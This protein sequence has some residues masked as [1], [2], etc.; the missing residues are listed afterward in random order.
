M[1]G[2]PV[3]KTYSSV[4]P[5]EK[6]HLFPDTKKILLRSHHLEARPETKGGRERG[7]SDWEERGKGALRNSNPLTLLSF[8][9]GGRLLSGGG[10]G[11]GSLI[12]P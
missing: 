4:R 6:N 7:M 5:P 2:I 3:R 10:G 12:M 8:P 1:N 11:G 9:L